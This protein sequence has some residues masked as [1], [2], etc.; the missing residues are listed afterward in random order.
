LARNLAQID[1][2]YLFFVSW[3]LR[4]AGPPLKTKVAK[5]LYDSHLAITKLPADQKESG[6]EGLGWDELVAQKR[7]L[8]NDLKV[9]TE[10][11]IDIDKNQFNAITAEIREARANMDRLK[12]RLHAI[13]NEVEK[14]N[15]S[16]YSISEKI[17]QAKNFLSVMEARLPPESEEVLQKIVQENELLLSSNSYRTEREKNEIMS[18]SKEASMKLE[19]I[20]A[21]RTIRDQFSILT[22]ETSKISALTQQLDTERNSTRNSI[23]ETNS[24]LDRLYDGKRKLTAERESGLAEYDRIARE[25]DLINARLDSMSEMRRKQREEYGHGLPSDALFKVKETARKKLEAGGKLTFEELK[26]L[27]GEKD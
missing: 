4:L 11:I 24:T 3:N 12:D 15:A 1:K 20:K 22:Q 14:N 9:I 21:T 17:S 25:F 27:Y 8:S 13:D 26:L 2:C 16:L 19:A 23:A 5:F 6:T 10:K 18:K 7:K